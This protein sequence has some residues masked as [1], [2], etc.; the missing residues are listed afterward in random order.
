MG[1]FTIAFT[2]EFRKE[3]LLNRIENLFASICLGLFNSNYLTGG[4][5]L[6]GT[7]KSKLVTDYI[8]LLIKMFISKQHS[9]ALKLFQGIMIGTG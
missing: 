1:L 2:K 6:F 8:N 5:Y 7:T 9:S 3:I 4:F